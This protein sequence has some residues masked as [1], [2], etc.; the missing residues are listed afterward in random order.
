[1]LLF[2]RNQASCRRSSMFALSD[3]GCMNVKDNKN[4][5]KTEKLVV[6]SDTVVRPEISVCLPQ[7]KLIN[8]R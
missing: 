2:P 8:C 7:T 1:M 3:D 4:E 6:L 5:G